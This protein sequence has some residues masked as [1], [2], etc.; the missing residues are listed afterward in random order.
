MTKLEELRVELAEIKARTAGQ[1]LDPME[2]D[3]TSIWWLET[4]IAALEAGESETVLDEI[5]Y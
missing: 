4:A 1:R 3:H 2:A 5:P